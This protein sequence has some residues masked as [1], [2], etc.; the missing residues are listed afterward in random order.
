MENYPGGGSGMQQNPPFLNAHHLY[1]NSHYSSS[2]A[3]YYPQSQN[4]NPNPNFPNP[5]HG[6][7]SVNAVVIQPPGVYEAHQLVLP[8]SYSHQTVASAPTAYYQDP[9]A[10]VTPFG[11]NSYAAGVTVPSTDAQKL[12]TLNPTSILRTKSVVRSQKNSTW[13]KGP[14]IIK[15]VQSAWCEICRVDC[16]SKNV[17]D[18]HK[19]GKKH[20][21]NLEKLTMANTSILAP[22][23]VL[24]PLPPASTVSDNPV[25]GPQENPDKVKT[26]STQKAHK[27]TADA[28]DLETKRKKVL[29]GGAALDAVRTCAICNVVCNSETV[30]RYHL[31]G[32]KHTAM[33]KRHA[34]PTGVAAAT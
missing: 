19:L 33:M 34:Y 20:K 28:E 22:A 26:A 6:T 32:Q 12:V 13:K 15:V 16:N 3:A 4:P 1:H 31:A 14:K 29:E 10:V 17:L 25:I 7:N 8:Y 2:S 18:L 27:K 24:A 9:N 5:N 11:L 23:P 21:K 30:F